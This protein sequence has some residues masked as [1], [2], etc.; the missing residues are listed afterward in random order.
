MSVETA[1]GGAGRDPAHLMEIDAPYCDVI[2]TRWQKLTGLDA[3]LEAEGT[4][5]FAAV[6]D[7]RGR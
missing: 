6:R 2:V 7:E 3:T 4:P 1:V 5:T